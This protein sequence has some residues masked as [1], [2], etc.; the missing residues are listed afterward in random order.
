M[1]DPKPRVVV[2]A[3]F[4]ALEY[5]T[6]AGRGLEHVA[7]VPGRGREVDRREVGDGGRAVQPHAVAPELGH[8][9]QRRIARL[10]MN[11][12]VNVRPIP[13]LDQAQLTR[14]APAVA[15][16]VVPEAEPGLRG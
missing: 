6:V 13:V 3:V 10:A 12:E 1:R 7:R 4:Q 8:D 9:P 5:V 16:H 15:V 14:V 2:L 11:P